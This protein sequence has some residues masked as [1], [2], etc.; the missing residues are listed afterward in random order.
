MRKII[1]S[2]GTVAM[3]ATV[4]T[5]AVP[6]TAFAKGHHQPK[7]DSKKLTCFSGTEDGGYGGTCTITKEK[8]EPVGAILDNTDGNSNGDYSGVYIPKNSLDEK[9]LS[10]IKHLSFE[11]T[12]TPGAGAPRFSIPIDTNKDGVTDFYAFVSALY[13]NDGDGFVDAINDSTCTIYAGSE[14]F[15]NWDALVAAHPDW[16]TTDDY[17][18]I[19]ADEAGYWTVSNINIGK[20]VK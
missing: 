10:K 17:A 3:L 20:K 9:K 19:I 6:S 16:M 12:G 15:A 2:I 1:S 18:F 11:Y 4:L 7:H 13:C 14:S 5:V 8:G